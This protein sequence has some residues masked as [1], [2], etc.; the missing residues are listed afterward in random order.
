AAGLGPL[1]GKIAALLGTDIDE[2][3]LPFRYRERS[4]PRH[5]R[6]FEPCAPFGFAEIEPLGRQRLIGR[7][8]SALGER[9][10]TRLVVIL[11]LT[12]PLAGGVLGQRFEYQRRARYIVE[13]RLEPVVKQR[14]PMLEAAMASAFAHRVVEEVVG[15]GGAEG[16]YVTEAEAPDR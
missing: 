14:Q 10:L 2:R 16:R 8:R 5:R 13:Q 12:E 7:A 1:G 6:G 11:D 4:Q 15:R 9:L 3:P